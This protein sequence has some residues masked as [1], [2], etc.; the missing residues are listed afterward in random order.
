MKQRIPTLDEHINENI[1]EASKEWIVSAN[2]GE[3]M[4]L[5]YFGK[6]WPCI[7]FM[8]KTYEQPGNQIVPNMI[9]GRDNNGKNPS[10]SL[11]TD[12]LTVDGVKSILRQ[13]ISTPWPTD[14]QIIEFVGL[15]QKK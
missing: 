11:K 2:N 12:D 1:N 6:T 8:H 15:I 10:A 9:V 14:A 5:R 13:G 7:A 3:P 4:L